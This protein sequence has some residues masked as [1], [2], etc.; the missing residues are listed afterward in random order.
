MDKT[1]KRVDAR[2]T[3][4]EK[5]LA[6]AKQQKAAIMEAQKKMRSKTMIR[7]FCNH[8]CSTLAQFD[9]PEVIASRIDTVLKIDCDKRGIVFTNFNMEAKN[10]SNR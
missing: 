7:S 1:T 6:Q 8:I 3:K 4:L 2:I 5:Q 9:E 10:A